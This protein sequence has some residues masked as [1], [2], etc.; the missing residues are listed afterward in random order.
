MNP[1]PEPAFSR[2]LRYRSLES[3]SSMSDRDRADL[4]DQIVRQE[5]GESAW[6]E[7]VELFAFW[8][9]NAARTKY[10]NEADAKLA[11]W[12]DGLRFL[13]SA[14]TYLYESGRLAP[15]ASLIRR[16]QIYR[17]EEQGGAD[18]KAIATSEHARQLSSLE[19]VRSEISGS[20][21]MA[22]VESPYLG[23]LRELAVTRTVLMEADIRR[24]FESQNF[25]RLQS[26]KLSGVGLTANSLESIRQSIPFP[27]LR[28]ID[29]AENLLEEEGVLLLSRSPW[30]AA[31]EDMELRHNFVPPAAVRALLLS[32]HSNRLRHLGASENFD[33][34]QEKAALTHMAREKNVELEV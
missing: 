5:P 12:D 2:L 18:L 24:L 30:L 33:S 19:I 21:W 27:E 7:L 31:I 29:F 3:L 10:L 20:S 13:P 17:R 22:L 9:A 4:L 1:H 23:N 34:M 26:L 28:K 14:T 25:P 8:P 6:R 16:I 15:L 32:R 11:H